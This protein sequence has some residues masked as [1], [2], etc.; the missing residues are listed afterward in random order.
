M[1]YPLRKGPFIVAMVL[2]EAI[3]GFWTSHSLAT[4]NNPR[5]MVEIESDSCGGR[6]FLHPLK[7]HPGVFSRFDSSLGH[8]G[9]D[10]SSKGEA[11]RSVSDGKIGTIGWDLRSLPAVN[12]RTGLKIR[13][14]GR[15]VVV[16]HSD[17]SESLYAHLDPKSTKAL[18]VGQAVKA[19]DSIGKSDTSGGVTGSHLHFEYS[20][21]G[22]IYKKTTKVDPRTCLAIQSTVSLDT[23]LHDGEGVFQVFIGDRLVG[24]NPAGKLAKFAISLKPGKYPLRVIA[25]QVK[26]YRA[27]YF[28]ISLGEGLTFLNEAGD[29]LG[30]GLAEEVEQGKTVESTLL[31][32]G[33]ERG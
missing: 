10:F 27:V 28:S 31:V 8:Y 30:P 18:K 26:K 13:G 20:P 7:S 32:G 6:S 29:E 16:Q 22:M 2:A 17:G 3:G 1:I 21:S 5:P 11:V 15:Y 9:T 19:G 24:E 14:W 4:E 33:R 12:P 23:Y 25:K